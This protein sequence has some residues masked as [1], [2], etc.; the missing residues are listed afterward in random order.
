MDMNKIKT[1][2]IS[3][4][5]LTLSGCSSVKVE[6]K[7]VN[8]STTSKARP[9][10]SKDYAKSLEE[11]EKENEITDKD[12]YL[13]RAICYYHLN[14][15]DLA[16]SNFKKDKKINGE[17]NE[18]EFS[19]YYDKM[20]IYFDDNDQE[21]IEQIISLAI[22]EGDRD[23]TTIKIYA[24]DNYEKRQKWFGYFKLA[25]ESTFIIYDSEIKKLVR[26]TETEFSKLFKETFFIS[27]QDD[28]PL[29][30]EIREK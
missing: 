29:W 25:D 15:Y 24:S 27:Y 7:K 18:S 5:C 30:S 8:Q 26:V 12:V 16:L 22:K 28:V 20:T 14:N 19:R 6:H 10:S 21:I 3:L 11:L 4:L 13:K 9:F 17:K 2:A 23:K 1:I